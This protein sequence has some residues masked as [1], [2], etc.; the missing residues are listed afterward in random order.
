LGRAQSDYG[1]YRANASSPRVLGLAGSPLSGIAN[2]KD[3]IP[4]SEYLIV[5][6]GYNINPA[7]YL[8][9]QSNNRRSVAAVDFED[10]RKTIPDAR[11]YLLGVIT[12]LIALLLRHLLSPLLGMENPYLTAWAAVV[13]SA[14]YCGIGPSVVCLVISIVGIWYWFLPVFHS[15]RFQDPKGEISGMVLFSLLSGLIVALGEAN[16]QSKARSE[17]ELAER[18]RIEDELRKAQAQLEG[19]VQRRT[20]EL[21]IANQNLS[22][23]TATVRPQAEWLDAANDAIF[24]VGSDERITYWNKGAERLYGWASADA[25]GT[26]PPELL[27]TH[28]TVTHP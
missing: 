9:L 2:A 7:Y 20:T 18:R 4:Y 1:C 10:M 27:P 12:A 3:A 15:F 21:K 14:W 16:R 24:V 6:K 26:S 22:Q 17:Q 13:F 5:G 11:D 28:F 8:F 25:I 23:E 19:R